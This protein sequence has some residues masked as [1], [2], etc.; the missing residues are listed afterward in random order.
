MTDIDHDYDDHY[1]E[2]DCG[3]CPNSG[4]IYNESYA[5]ETCGEHIC[6]LCDNAERL[7]ADGGHQCEGCAPP[8]VKP[9]PAREAR[10]DRLE[11]EASKE[12]A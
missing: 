12:E 2:G 8:V 3:V 5:C 10:I 7:D 4:E 6:F 11:S 9:D 1:G